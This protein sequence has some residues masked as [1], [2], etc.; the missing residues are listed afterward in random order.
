MSFVIIM[1]MSKTKEKGK[2]YA[3][4]ISYIAARLSN[5]VESIYYPQYQQ[6]I[7]LNY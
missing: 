7:D 4:V 6:S 3:H 1:I 2:N 5:E